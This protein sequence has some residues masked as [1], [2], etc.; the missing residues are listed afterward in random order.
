MHILYKEEDN[1]FLGISF[2]TNIQNTIMHIEF[3]KWNLKECRRYKKIWEIIKKN[4]K[5]SGLTE[6]Y[7][8]C[9]SQ[10]NVKFNKFWGFKDT[11][12]I[13]YTLDNK[14]KYILKLE[15]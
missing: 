8:L 12:K 14:F 11:G 5:E 6:I 9:E 3:K 15:I 4:L 2:E 10:K 13:A 1:G 7:S